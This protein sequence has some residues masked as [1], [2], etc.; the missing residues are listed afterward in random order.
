MLPVLSLSLSLVLVLVLVPPVLPS[1][2]M[3]M[4]PVPLPA[5]LRDPGRGQRSVGLRRSL[6]RVQR[7]AGRA[8]G[9][10]RRWTGGRSRRGLYRRAP[11]DG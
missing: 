10:D 6:R 1:V 8:E 7:G 5:P 4:P 11:A 3:P 9:R 2:Q